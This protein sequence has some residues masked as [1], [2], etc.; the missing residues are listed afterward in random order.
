MYK[1]WSACIRMFFAGWFGLTDRLLFAR[2]HWIGDLPKNSLPVL[3]ISNHLSWW[4]GIWVW[5]QNRRLWKRAFSVPVLARSLRQWPFLKHLGAL[6][7]ERG[8]R[9]PAQCVAIQQ[10]CST[11][12]DLL[13]FFPEGSIR[14]SAPGAYLFKKALLER[15]LEQSSLQWVMLYQAVVT[16]DHPRCEVF[17]FLQSVEVNSVSE[18]EV[19]YTQFATACEKHIALEWEQRMETL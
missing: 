5:Q 3:L 8:R 16:T 1:V 10:A 15:F 19:A 7:L 2:H 12:D 9:L 11:A 17:H 4:D 6:P 14:R 18:L 13:L